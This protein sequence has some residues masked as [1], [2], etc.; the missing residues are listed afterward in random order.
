MDIPTTPQESLPLSDR[1]W[2]IRLLEIIPGTLTWLCLLLPVILSLRWP[3][4]VAYF[5]IAFDLIWLLKSTRLNFYLLLGYSRLHRRQ[6]LDWQS[7][8][9]DLNDIPTAINERQVE[10]EEFVSRHRSASRGYQ[11]FWLSS[12]QR[13]RYLNASDYLEELRRLGDHPQTIM[14]PDDLLNVVIIATYNESLEILEPSVKSI[15]ASHYSLKQLML[16]IAYEERGG[17]QT[18]HNAQLLIRKYGKQFA[19]AMA[20]KHP[21]GLPEEGKVKGANMTFAARQVTEFIAELEIEPERVIVSSFD[22]DHRPH[23]NYFAC[24]SY[25][26]ATSPNRTHKSY[27]PIPMFYN[28]IWDVPAPMRVIATGSSFWIIMQTLRPHLLR[29]FAAHA[30]SL[31]TLIDTDYWST[32]SIVEDGHQYWRSYFIYDGDHE[33]V[34]VFVPVY[35]DAVLAKTYRKTFKVQYIQ[36]RRWAWG[37]SDFPYVIRNSMKN[38]RI[39]L[40]EKIAQTARLVEG[41]FSWATAPLVLTFVAWLPLYL[42]HAFADQLLAH[43]LPVIA[44]RILGLA[45]LGLF[46]TVI[47]SMISLPPKP[48]RYGHRRRLGMVL[49]W[50][51]LPLTAIFFGAFAAI[52]SQTRLMI[53]KYLDWAVTEKATKQ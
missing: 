39:P 30:Q 22:S 9:N 4:L 51:L 37:I 26:Y 2:F 29:N 53:G 32:T 24:L 14:K 23:P 35:Q 48:P 8:L 52:D 38:R 10:V 3:I 5:I 28:N 25:Q 7:R 1:H 43:E 42:N 44:S 33:V 31:K 12:K 20:I 46:T 11:P 34:P 18:E 27:Q 41:H 40:G 13:R 49:Q 47:I 15:L 36:L 16:V 17:E 50:L 21:D 45:T 19:Y 6:N